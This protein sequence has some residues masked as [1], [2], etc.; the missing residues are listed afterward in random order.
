MIK[1]ANKRIIGA[2]VIG[3]VILFV[4]AITVFGSGM[5]FKVSDKYVLFFDGSVKG[6]SEGAPV[7]FKGVR[8][9]SVSDISIVYEP[10]IEDVLIVVIIDVELSR[11]KGA[12]EKLGY[13]DYKMLVDYGLRASL[14]V[15]NFITNQLMIGLDFYPD[16][17]AKMHAFMKQYPELPTLPISGDIFKLMNE[18][19]IKEIADGLN[20]TVAGINKLVN[21]EGLDTLG[22][23]IQEIT[24]AAR[25]L[26]LF[27]EYLEQH[28]EAIL[29]GKQMP[30]GE[31]K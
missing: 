5:L 4:T 16:K 19:P 28:P 1:K 26:S 23:A 11:V 8:I 30:R 27:T 14:E 7:I 3:A 21:S 31:R 9:G 2:F 17:P 10:K 22:S 24:Q 29:K 6:L 13:T 18:L 15:Q 25:S 20:Q 12:P